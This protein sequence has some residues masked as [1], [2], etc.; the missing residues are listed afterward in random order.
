M[1]DVPILTFIKLGAV[2]L[3]IAI[4]GYHFYSDW[5]TS[6]E[7]KEVNTEL[8]SKKEAF[9]VLE[10][11]FVQATTDLGVLQAKIKTADA[12]RTKIQ[13]DLSTALAKLRGQKAPKECKA[14]I[15]WSVLNKTDLSW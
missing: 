15:D 7:L 3:V 10:R 1:F 2:G 8:S 14:A 5:S 6:N 12:E 9:K 11:D 4:V 13:L